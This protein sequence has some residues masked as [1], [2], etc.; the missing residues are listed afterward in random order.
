MIRSIS[1]ALAHK[2]SELGQ[3]EKGFTLIELLVVVIII[4]ILA[5]IAIPIFLGQQASARDGAVK[6]DI[7]N[8]KVA[9]VGFMAASPTGAAPANTAALTDFTPGTDTNITV[10]ATATGFCIA[11]F[12]SIN[13][14]GAVKYK[15]T[16]KTGITTGNC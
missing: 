4:G 14:T 5:A 7:A 10:T 12:S 11:G 15:A 8:A 2:R 6:S 16:D 3:K 1:E 13:G 9:A